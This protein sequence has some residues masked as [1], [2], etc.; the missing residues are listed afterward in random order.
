MLIQHHKGYLE[1]EEIAEIGR[2]YDK[3]TASHNSY[4]NKDT[5]LLSTLFGSSV[6][7]KLKASILRDYHVCEAWFIIGERYNWHSDVHVDLFS[8]KVINLWIPYELSTDTDSPV[9]EYYDE[10]RPSRKRVRDSRNLVRLLIVTRSLA[11]RLASWVDLRRVVE[12]LFAK[13]LGGK[14]CALRQA[15]I[16]DVLVLDPSF[17]HRSGSRKKKVLTIQCVPG[18]V[19]RDPSVSFRHSDLTSLAARKAL[20]AISLQAQRESDGDV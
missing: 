8:D 16:G 7:K 14:L 1:S 11:N 12:R 6:F 13:L 15:E 2:M 20:A 9:I 5:A 10:E 3:C 18:I 17:L 4:Q 19:L